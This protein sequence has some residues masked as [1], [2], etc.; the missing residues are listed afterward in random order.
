MSE[1]TFRLGCYEVLVQPGQGDRLAVTC[2]GLGVPALDQMSFEFRRTLDQ[3]APGGH[4][5][6]IKD[7]SRSWYNSPGLEAVAEFLDGYR[8]EHGIRRSVGFGLSAGA[9][10]IL[11]LSREAG[12]DEVLA[13]SPRSGFGPELAL[14]QRSP[15]W[16]AAIRHLPLPDLCELLPGGSAALTVLFSIDEPEDSLQALRLQSVPGLRLLATRGPHNLAERLQALGRLNGVFSDL[17]A[18]TPVD[19]AALGCFEPPAGLAGLARARLAHEALPAVDLPP[20]RL[21]IYHLIQRGQVHSA[22]VF[23]YPSQLPTF[24]TDGWSFVGQAGV[25]SVGPDHRLK[26]RVADFA[27]QPAVTMV[28]ELRPFLHER[29]PRQRL[30]ARLNGQPLPERELRWGQPEAQG[31]A[32]E[33]PLTGPEVVL[34]LHTP[35]AVSPASLGLSQDRRALGVLA[36]GLSFRP[37]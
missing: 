13:L 12:L 7:L 11:R 1:R 10:G 27:A 14:D 26:A 35:D 5:V 29:H 9:F 8:R 33:V 34:D 23:E 15:E 25:W 32:L 18:G 30:Q 3:V 31:W 4:A 16:V 37:F 17:L 21:P 6:F 20:E 28:L 36:R 19:W 22:A 2:S 24:L